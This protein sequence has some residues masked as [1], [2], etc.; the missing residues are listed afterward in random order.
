MMALSR[1]LFQSG[2][3][4]AIARVCLRQVDADWHPFPDEV[5]VSKGL[6]TRELNRSFSTAK[7][8]GIEIEV[9]YT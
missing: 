9:G 1:E 8:V 5:P 2:R 3:I 6:R 7:G 4:S